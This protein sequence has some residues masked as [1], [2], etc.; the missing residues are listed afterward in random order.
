MSQLQGRP[1]Q[2]RH[3]YHRPFR[4]SGMGKQNYR[5]QSGIKRRGAQQPRFS[6]RRLHREFENG[7]R[8]QKPEDH[9]IV[10]ECSPNEKN[11]CSKY[12]FFRFYRKYMGAIVFGQYCP[13]SF[14]G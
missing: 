3:F 10:I 6:G 2:S 13:F 12:T 14:T 4:E 9:Q 8:G 7:Y 5:G 11:K 1:R